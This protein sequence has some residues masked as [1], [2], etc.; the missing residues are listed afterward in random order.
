VNTGVDTLEALVIEVLLDVE[1]KAQ[2]RCKVHKRKNSQIM[3]DMDFKAQALQRS[4]ISQT[5][6]ANSMSKTLGIEIG[7]STR[8]C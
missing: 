2:R 4:Q 8:N 6:H 5:Y 3:L 7:K 1:V